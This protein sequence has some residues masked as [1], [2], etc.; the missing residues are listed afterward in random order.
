MVSRKQAAEGSVV[1]YNATLEVRLAQDGRDWLAWC[2]PI[3]LMTQAKTKSKALESIKEAVEGWFESCMERGVLE[4]ALLEAGFINATERSE[5]PHGVSVVGLK[6]IS[7]EKVAQT[8][9]STSETGTATVQAAFARPR[10]GKP[11]YIEVSIPAYI[12][13]QY[14]LGNAISASR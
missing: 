13:A 1:R 3:D 10:H 8:T 14:N 9:A 11:R 6:T 4:A 12:A 7:R 2:Q 5:V